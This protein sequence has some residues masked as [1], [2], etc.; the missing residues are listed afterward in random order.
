[1]DRESS[2]NGLAPADQRLTKWKSGREAR[3]IALERE[4]DQAMT[5]IYRDRLPAVVRDAVTTAMPTGTIYFV[6]P[7]G[8][9]I[10]IG[11]ASRLEFR[12]KDLRTMNALPLVVHATAD[13][14]PSLER[15][16]HKRF[17]VH[18][19]HGEWFTPHP[20]I[21]AE[22]KRLNATPGPLA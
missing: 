21:L 2:A 1:M 8:G 7:I 12:L 13:G 16:Y 6:G 18:R 9:P 20:D 15:E 19:L 14:P 4:C 11:F 22:I 5:A 10:K 17:A 3:R